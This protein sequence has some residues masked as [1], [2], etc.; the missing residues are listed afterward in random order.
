[1]IYD[2]FDLAQDKFSIYDFFCVIR[3]IRGLRK[4][5]LIIVTAPSA[6]LINS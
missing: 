3:E 4:L 2:P 6:K 1:M 5:L